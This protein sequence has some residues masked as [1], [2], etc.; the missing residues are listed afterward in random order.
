MIM[1]GMCAQWLDRSQPV[2]LNYLLIRAWK[3]G[4]VSMGQ[5][6]MKD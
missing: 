6:A 3:P 5:E 4:G 2:Q 1:S